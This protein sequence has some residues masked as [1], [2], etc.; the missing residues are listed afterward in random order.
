MNPN[1]PGVSIIKIRYLCCAF[2]QAV[3]KA[4]QFT[5]GEERHDCFSY[6]WGLQGWEKGATQ[7]PLANDF[8]SRSCGVYSLP[9]LVFCSAASSVIP[10]CHSLPTSSISRLSAR[11]SFSRNVATSAEAYK[12]LAWLLSA[13][14]HA[15]H[16]LDLFDW[17]LS[18]GKHNWAAKSNSTSKVTSRHPNSHKHKVYSSP[19]TAVK[20]YKQKR[21][22]LSVC[23]TTLHPSIEL[24]LHNTT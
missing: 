1:V 21:R 5:G 16:P 3:K 17:S 2:L 12:F 19:L 6:R 24:K 9:C 10:Q 15:V 11:D 20:P 23:A 18:K 8:I 4:H 13:F 14:L 22:S 7:A